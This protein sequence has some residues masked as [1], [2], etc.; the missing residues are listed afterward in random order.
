MSLDRFKSA[1]ASPESG[2]D[3]ALAEIR[4]GGKRGH[5]IWYVFPQLA[6]LGR[7]SMAQAYGIRDEAEAVAFLADRELRER[8]LTITRAVADQLRK[9]PAPSL[10]TVMGSAIDAQK[11]VSSLTLFGEVAARLQA[12]DPAGPHAAFVRAAEEVL[13]AAAAEGYS[14][15]AYTRERLGSR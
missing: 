1:Q 3:A 5:W 11:L 12:R 7:S 8:L 2:F 13:S 14:A 15:C 10:R 6:G 4:G 9:Q